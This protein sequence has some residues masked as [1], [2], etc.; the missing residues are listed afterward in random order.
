MTA[1]MRSVWGILPGILL[2]VVVID[3][4]SFFNPVFRVLLTVL[5]AGIILLCFAELEYSFADCTAYPRQLANSKN[6]QH[7]KQDKRYLC[8][9]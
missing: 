6:Y 8:R 5:L 9:A 4:G 7:N 3:G 2:R 1:I